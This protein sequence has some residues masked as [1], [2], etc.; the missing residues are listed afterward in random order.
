M[1]QICYVGFKRKKASPVLHDFDAIDPYG[2]IVCH[3][4][5]TQNKPLPLPE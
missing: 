2:S 4:I 1:N 3:S 5:K